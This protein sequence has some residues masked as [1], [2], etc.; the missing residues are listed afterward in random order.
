MTMKVFWMYQECV[1][2]IIIENDLHECSPMDNYCKL[3]EMCNDIY[4]YQYHVESSV[5]KYSIQFNS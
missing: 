4:V 5:V 1:K 3:G 2:K